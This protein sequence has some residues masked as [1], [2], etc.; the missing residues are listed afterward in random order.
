MNRE[1]EYEIP[2][3]WKYRYRFFSCLRNRSLVGADDYPYPSGM[4]PTNQLNLI[5]NTWSGGNDRV[6][7]GQAIFG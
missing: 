7:P 5:D 4:I 2:K 3:I 6:A 1:I